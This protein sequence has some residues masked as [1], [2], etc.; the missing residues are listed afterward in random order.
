[1]NPKETA[2][3]L[4]DEAYAST[5]LAT[6]FVDIDRLSIQ[7]DCFGH[8]HGASTPIVTISA[9]AMIMKGS[10]GLNPLGRGNWIFSSARDSVNFAKLAGRNKVIQI[11]LR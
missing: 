7:N 3:T 2:E 8:T 5:Q 1:M 6:I 11:D 4:L 9:G 10:N